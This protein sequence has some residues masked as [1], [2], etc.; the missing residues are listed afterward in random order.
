MIINPTK[1]KFQRTLIDDTFYELLRLYA[2]S[3]EKENSILFTLG[4]SFADEHIRDIT[5]RAA[6]S[7]PTLQIIVFAF[8]D[9]AQQTIKKE[10]GIENQPARNS[11]ITVISPSDFIKANF[12]DEEDKK[13]ILKRITNFDFTTILDEVLRPVTKLIRIKAEL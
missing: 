6:S 5:L 7:N 1:E 9:K 11:N 8:D 4:F 3:L 10:L 13:K 12:K 2:N